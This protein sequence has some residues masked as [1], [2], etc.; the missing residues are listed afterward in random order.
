MGES[1]TFKCNISV[2]YVGIAMMIKATLIIVI[3]KYI[4][5]LNTVEKALMGVNY[6][7]MYTGNS[8]C[9]E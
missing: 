1:E 6:C 7:G 3:L 9:K 4:S 5:Q 8:F 2:F